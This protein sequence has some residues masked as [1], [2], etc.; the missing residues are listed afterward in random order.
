MKSIDMIDFIAFQNFLARKK[1]TFVNLFI[2]HKYIRNSVKLFRRQTVLNY[3]LLNI[4]ILFAMFYS[5]LNSENMF[6]KV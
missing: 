2:T 6:L 4:F 1:N 3:K 5:H